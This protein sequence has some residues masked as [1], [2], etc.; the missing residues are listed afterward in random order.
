MPPGSGVAVAMEQAPG[1]APIR[2]LTWELPYAT[3]KATKGKNKNK[4]KINKQ[5]QFS[6]S[7]AHNCLCWEP[8]NLWSHYRY[9][10]NSFMKPFDLAT[11][12]DN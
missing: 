11:F 10:D 12:R 7:N 6:G 8:E 2:P 1:A 4:I 3:V 5:K 9:D